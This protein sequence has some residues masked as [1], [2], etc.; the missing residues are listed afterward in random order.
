MNDLIL[1][2]PNP[3]ENSLPAVWDLVITDMQTRDQAGLEKYG[4]RLLSRIT[5]EM[6]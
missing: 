3:R 6:F 4:T 1:P 2:Q 5:V